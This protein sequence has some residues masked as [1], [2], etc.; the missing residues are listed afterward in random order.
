MASESLTPAGSRPAIMAPRELSGD[1]SQHPAAVYLA[2][3]GPGSRRAMRQALDT[4]ARLL[5]GGRAVAETL[6]WGS[7]RYQHVQAVRSVLA[8]KLA[9]GTVN[10]VLSAL[11]GVL[12]EAWKLGQIDAETYHR[13][14]AVRRVRGERLPAGRELTAG[15]IRALFRTC[16]NDPAPSGARDAA[17]LALLYGAGLRRSELVAL[18]LRDYQADS[19]ELTVR[20]GKGGKERTVYATDGAEIALRT[21]LGFRGEQPGPLICPVLKGGRVVIRGMTSQAVYDALRKR[22]TQASVEHFSP[23][24]CRRTF[25]SHLLDAGA[26][27]STVQRLAGHASVTTTARYDRRGEAAKRKA[28]ELLHVPYRGP[29][30]SKA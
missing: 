2:S 4:V 17:I 18:E 12:R 8:E 14:A 27:I 7:L 9:P 5:S 21:W 6:P 11:R 26:D 16:A 22:A 20:L 1:P 29:R 23:H 30:Q 24:D 25:V 28:S 13:A 15:E 3:L 10:K 19:G